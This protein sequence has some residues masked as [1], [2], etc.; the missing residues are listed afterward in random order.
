MVQLNKSLFNV[1]N[2][3]RSQGRATCSPTGAFIEG[4]TRKEQGGVRSYGSACF[5]VAIKRTA[6][7]IE[8][9]MYMCETLTVRLFLCWHQTQTVCWASVNT[10]SLMCDWKSLQD[11]YHW[12]GK[13]NACFRPGTKIKPRDGMRSQWSL[14]WI[15]K[16][17]TDSG[18]LREEWIEMQGLKGA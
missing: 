16:V 8:G 6:P 5:T 9:A 12:K 2:R 15:M 11:A 7:H 4:E 17:R 3:R 13:T 14:K 1:V 10:Y 18:G